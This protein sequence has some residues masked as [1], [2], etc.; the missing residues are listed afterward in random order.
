MGEEKITATW[1]ISLDCDCPHCEEYV[2]LLEYADFW[3][4]LHHMQ[5]G[6]HGTELSKDM[7]VVCPKCSKGFK[8]DLEY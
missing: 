6:E 1:N 3:D 5:I 8:V 2:D 7:E 4:G